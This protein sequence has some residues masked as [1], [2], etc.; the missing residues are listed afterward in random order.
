MIAIMLKKAKEH[1]T[2]RV[3]RVVKQIVEVE[4]KARVNFSASA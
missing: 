3:P 4:T 1:L 2:A